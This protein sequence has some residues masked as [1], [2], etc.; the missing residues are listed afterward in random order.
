MC[1]L[2]LK[3][4]EEIFFIPIKV[5]LDARKENCENGKHLCLVNN[6]WEDEKVDGYKRF[7]FFL[8]WLRRKMRK[9]KK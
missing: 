1:L 8:I 9:W 2:L 4:L 6:K 3:L 5:C 7:M